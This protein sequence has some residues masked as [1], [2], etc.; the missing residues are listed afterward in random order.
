MNDLLDRLERSCQKR[1][2]CVLAIL[3][4]CFLSV[5]LPVILYGLHGSGDTFVY[6]AFGEDVRQ[7]WAAGQIFP[8]WGSGG[9]SYGSVGIRF[10]P[11][12]SFY[13]LAALVSLSGSW[14]FALLASNFLWMFVG[15]WG[16]FLFVRDR[17]N[18][19]WG[20][21]AALVYAFIPFHLAEI[22]Q[23][24]LIGEFAAGAILPYCFLYSA[25]LCERNEHRD[26]VGFSIAFGFLILTHIP[27]TMIAALT[28]GLFILLLLQR[29]V[30]QTLIRFT[31]AGAISLAWTSFYW[32]KVVAEANW[33][34][35]NTSRF[36][37]NFTDYSKWL[38]PMSVFP[39]GTNDIYIPI[40]RNI[41]AMVTITALLFLHAIVVLLL[42]PGLDRADQRLIKWLRAMSISAVFGSFMLSSLSSFFW[43]GIPLLQKL[44][45]PWRWLGIVSVI[46]TAV[47]TVSLFSLVKQGSKSRK[48][49]VAIGVAAA[50]I[51]GSYDVR[52]S[53]LRSNIITNLEIEQ[54][55]EVRNAPVGTTL[56][57][58]WPIW[59]KPEA[60]KSSQKISSE[61]EVLVKKH[62][63]D[64]LEFVIGN[65]LPETIRVGTFYYPHW[66]AKING[67][68]QNIASDENGAILINIGAEASNVELLFE[69]PQYVH[70][71]TW[72]SMATVL[73]V[74]VLFVMSY[75]QNATSFSSF[76]Q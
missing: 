20:V 58:W 35:H 4:I 76:R 51:I 14:Y 28:I 27:S 71:S 38:F 34:A 50:I 42:S 70:F 17:A 74:L 24:S 66:K 53:F 11:P 6:L 73:F 47:F 67:I 52:Q 33:V 48:I 54:M 32:L 75:R 40:Y 19:S 57:A 46:A 68:V 63:P 37:S 3:V 30:L 45:F 10:Y 13:T 55:L 23:F 29:P 72:L 44:Q 31:V 49:A 43:N 18:G 56:E 2:F 61:R 39:D 60:F 65:G 62:D 22:Y 21:A 25:R 5:V 41:D 26:I 69:E 36:A 8:S 1:W 9:L 59:A 64:H 7:A 15:C 16:I 12:V